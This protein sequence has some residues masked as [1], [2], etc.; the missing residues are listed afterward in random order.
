MIKSIMLAVLSLVLGGCHSTGSS[1]KAPVGESI[2]SNT[3]FTDAYQPVQPFSF[4][5]TKYARSI[6]P[7]DCMSTDKALRKACWLDNL[8]NSEDYVFIAD[9]TSGGQ[10]K[11]GTTGVSAKGGKYEIV[12]QW[13]RFINVKPIDSEG[14]VKSGEDHKVGVGARIVATISTSEADI[15]LGDLFAVAAAA[16]RKKVSGSLLFTIQGIHGKGVDTYTPK[17]SKLDSENLLKALESIQNIKMLLHT[18]K[19]IEVTGQV[20]AIRSFPQQDIL[21]QLI[22]DEKGTKQP[23]GINNSRQGWVYVGHFDK[24]TGKPLGVTNLAVR[25]TADIKGDLTTKGPLNVRADYPDFPFY[26]LAPVIG[27]IGGG[28]TV[29]L[30]NVRKTGNEKYWAFVEYTPD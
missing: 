6:L 4:D 23:E 27:Q 7:S 8:P 13:V 11:Y 19:E 14:A 28:K 22:E 20:V 12:S 26:K 21:N 9:A 30:L 3:Y 17:V 1:D 2:L 10:L 24:T 16:E 29:S 5:P 18:D 15:N 25:S